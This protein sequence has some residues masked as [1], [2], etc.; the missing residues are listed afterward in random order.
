MFKKLFGKKDN[1]IKLVSPI[2]GEII[3]I[4]EVNDQ[5][6][7]SGMLGKGVGIKPTEGKV[8]APANGEITIMFPTKHAVSILT[9][10]GA[11]LL[12]HIGLDTVNLQGEH[13][14]SHVEVGQKVKVGD[15]LVEFEAEKIKEAGYDITSPVLVCNPDNF[16]SVEAI[17]YGPVELGEEII[18]MG[19]K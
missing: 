5:T 17:K 3:P 11:E 14:T 16:E 18:K 2:K 13:F 4:E 8:L 12:I 7:A 10:D 6:F 19:R 15:L 1:S 9:E